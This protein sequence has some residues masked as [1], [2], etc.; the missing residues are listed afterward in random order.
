MNTLKEWIENKNQDPHGKYMNVV[1]DPDYFKDLLAF[2][3]EQLT[4]DFPGRSALEIKQIL[5]EISNSK[6]A[7]GLAL[8]PTKTWDLFEAAIFM[9]E[10]EN[11][12]TSEYLTIQGNS[13]FKG[14][15]PFEDGILLNI[16]QRTY[17]G[18]D[19]WKRIIG[20]PGHYIMDS[21]D[22]L[23]KKWR[24][25]QGSDVAD[26]NTQADRIT[27]G[28]AKVLIDLKEEEF[29]KWEFGKMTPFL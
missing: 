13:V 18:I 12:D 16:N 1:G 14:K 5:L 28:L 27:L 8:S 3:R 22:F 24:L 11:K 6:I 26:A 17:K 15:Q 9:E 20:V 2:F 10:L 25:L 21:Y 29:F 4:L 7:L 23:D 19:G